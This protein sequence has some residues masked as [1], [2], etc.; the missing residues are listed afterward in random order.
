MTRELGARTKG[1][2]TPNLFLS[3]EDTHFKIFINS[4]KATLLLDK[5]DI[6]LSIILQCDGGK[7]LRRN[8]Q[9]ALYVQIRGKN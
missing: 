3:K 8:E 5:I 2:F 6:H 9:R 1:A 4:V 7:Y